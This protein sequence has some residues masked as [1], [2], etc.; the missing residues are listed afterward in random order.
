MCVLLCLLQCLLYSPLQIY[1]SRTVSEARR[2]QHLPSTPSGVA[3]PPVAGAYKSPP[4]EEKVVIP[5]ITPMRR[6]RP[7]KAGVNHTASRPSPSPLRTTGDPF[8]ALDSAPGKRGSVAIDDISSRFPPLEQF[9]LLHDSGTKFAFDSKPSPANSQPKD[10]NQRVTEALADDAFAQPL[11]TKK[12]TPI[13]SKSVPSVVPTSNILKSGISRVPSIKTTRPP[14]VLEPQPQ[15]PSMVSTGT[16]TSPSP[17]P[18]ISK[19]TT[20]L[21]RPI[22]HFPPTDLRSSS[23]PGIS[24]GTSN[25]SVI[26]T[27]DSTPLRPLLLNKRSDS[28]NAVSLSQKI[29]VSSRPSLES[30]RPST[31][32]LNN[33]ISRSKSA[34]T[35]PRPS[36][37]YIESSTS[38]ANARASSHDHPSTDEHSRF[39]ELIPIQSTLTGAPDDSAEPTKIDSNVDFLKAMEEEDPV[40]RKEK[41]SS[42]GSK[43]SK[44]ASMPSLS[45]SGTKSLLAG[46]FGEAFRRFESSGSEQREPSP[47]RE[48]RGNGLTPIAGSEATD[49]RSDDGEVIEE[50]DEVSPEVRRELERRRLSQEERRVADGAAAYRRRLAERDGSNKGGSQGGQGNRAASIQNKVQSLLEDHG[51]SSTTTTTQGYGRF[52]DPPSPAFNRRNQETTIAKNR[53]E[54]ESQQPSTTTPV[55]ERIKRPITVTNVIP[56]QT[57]QPPNLISATPPAERPSSRPHAPPKPQALRTGGRG[58]FPSLSSTLPLQAGNASGNV[59]DWETNFSKRYPSLSGLEMVETEIDKKVPEGITI[60]DV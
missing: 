34:T 26:R 50:V 14:S 36:S 13:H 59:N 43:H 8:A 32:E 9:S 54:V 35:K 10:I 7:T 24:T 5:D 60:K 2:N 22:H 58:E 3:S 21:S 28:H 25:E 39:Q 16:M 18:P 11:T 37:A 31:L 57:T 51:R 15:R 33:P 53:G 49:G 19:S 30:Q 23:H 55:A 27:L 6:G 47:P 44:R 29:P 42:S 1:A 52:T 41:R 56:R 12:E 20:H 17:P 4:A 38:F 48:G 40:K 45:L 46:R